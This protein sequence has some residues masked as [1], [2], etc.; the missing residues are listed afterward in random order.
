M[1]E[2]HEKFKDK[3]ILPKDLVIDDNGNRKAINIDELKKYNA[4]TGDIGP[5][6]TEE[7]KSIIIKA[8]TIIANGPPGIFEKEVF[9][10]GTF[11]MVDLVA[12][13]VGT[14]V[15]YFVMIFTTSKRK[16]IA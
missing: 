13:A 5:K 16:E 14:A 8:K 10:K 1:P 11:D 7:F 3:I 4:V 12:I 9:R 2:V 6:T 15:A